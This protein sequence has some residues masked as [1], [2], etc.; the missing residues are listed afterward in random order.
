VATH[1]DALTST[2]DNAGVPL[3]FRV[4]RFTG[5]ALGAVGLLTAAAYAFANPGP[6]GTIGRLTWAFLGVAP[7]FA[8]AVWL[9]SKRPDHPQVRRK[10]LLAVALAISVG[11]EGP[12]QYGLF[13]HGPG[14]WMAWAN[15]V[16][17]F[18]GL[19]AMIAAAQLLASYPDGTVEHRWQRVVIRLTWLHLLLP[20]L[21]LLTSPNVVFDGY[22]FD[23][24]PV[25]ANPMAVPGL[26]WLAP[27]LAF[28][29]TGYYGGFVVIPILI[30]RFFQAGPQQRARMRLLVY[31]TAA[32]VPT[33][34]AQRALLGVVGEPPPIWYRLFSGLTIVLMLMIPVAI[35][36][37]IVRHRLFD[38]D[39][40]I[41]RSVVFAVLSVG[42]AAVY[43][44]LSAA[45]GLAL[46]NQIPVELAVVLTIFAAAVFQ[47]VRRW[48]ERVADRI[49]F[50]E[51]V[52]R[53]QLLTSF[54][55]SLEQTVGLHDLLPRLAETVRLGLAAR[56]V[57]VSLPGASA[58]AGEPSGEPTLTVPLERGGEVV[59]H[60]ECARDDDYADSDRELL[61]TLAGQAVTAITN[62][63]LTATLAEQVEE[64]A[65]SRARIVAAQDSERR[66][67]ER[68]LHDGAQQHVIALI[69][70][71]R[72]A[73]NQV[74]RGD[75]TADEVFTELQSDIREL[76]TDLRELAHGIHPPVLSD[77][78][79]VAAVEA[80]ADRLPL[81][82]RVRGDLHDQRLGAD[83]EGAA[84]FVICE[85]LTNIVKHAAARVAEIDLS[86]RDGQLVVRVH[87]DGI[88]L[89]PNGSNG[90]GLTN[91][92]D[93]VEALGGQIRVDS[94]PGAG[95]S[96]HA[97]LP[98]GVTDG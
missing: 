62:V 40:A 57:R 51:R 49:V 4:L 26:S 90:H 93:R 81:E 24:A 10:L 75:R 59:G 17:Q 96:V 54:G 47:P 66:R 82:V 44:G 53:Y 35:V 2:D 85:A 38:I 69:M 78:G 60:I 70:K 68:N 73:R 67:I 3:W 31:V 25:V 84:Y 77:Q 27:P 58:V 5:V 48:L 52:N 9:I 74:G 41:R 98:V 37:G 8:L 55:A 29:A 30:V 80:R 72:L 20:P 88:G 1:V 13:H 28:L 89:R 71:L 94:R 56:W 39:L 91:L 12:F 6:T 87:D 33:Y 16:P 86:T 23:P 21:L 76:L 43:V 50:G 42:I 92:R 34:F 18:C 22:T 79:L 61:A 65:Q 97:K 83:V 7:I 32:L 11:F 46:G 14:P 64:L 63:Q 45:P 36:I 95:T 15:L 19:L